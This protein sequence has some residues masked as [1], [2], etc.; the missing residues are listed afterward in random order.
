MNSRPC[1]GIFCCF[2]V[3]L[4]K[5]YFVYII[6][7]TNHTVFYTG[8]TSDLSARMTQHKEGAVDGFAKKYSCV[9]L[10]YYEYSED[11]Y[12]ILNEKNKLNDTKENGNTIL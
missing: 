10:L 4:M 3:R 6:S 8:M 7:N 1:A 5:T 12:S 11:I 2:I 9:K